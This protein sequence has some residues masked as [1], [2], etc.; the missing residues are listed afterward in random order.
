MKNS[1][2]FRKSEI[3]TRLRKDFILLSFVFSLLTFSTVTTT[4]SA[5]VCTFDPYIDC[6][7]SVT[8]SPR[9]GSVSSGG[10]MSISSTVGGIFQWGAVEVQYFTF[11][12]S[13]SGS[14]GASGGTV[15][16]NTG[17]IYSPIN[18]T[19]SVEN[20]EGVFRSDSVFINVTAPPTVNINFSFVDKVRQFFGNTFA[21][22]EVVLALEK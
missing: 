5:D 12:I 16:G 3:N 6:P 22:H 7:L 4:F 20:T 13:Y 2:P 9:G 19:T 17:A 21:K 1:T 18:V 14:M 11:S 10:N 8:L 15:T